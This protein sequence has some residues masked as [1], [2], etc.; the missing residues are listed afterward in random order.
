M[1]TVK[2]VINQQ[3]L[4]IAPQYHA[5]RA[6]L[7]STNDRLKMIPIFVSEKLSSDFETC[8]HLSGKHSDKSYLIKKF[9]PSN[10]SLI[11]TSVHPQHK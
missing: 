11:Y 8:K 3:E 2:T 9:S 5:R 7:L 4:V 6:K 10:N 1:D